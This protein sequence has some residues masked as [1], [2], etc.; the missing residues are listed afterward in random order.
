AVRDTLA[1]AIA[2][3]GS[4]LRDFVDARGKPGYFQQSYF[5]YERAG[6]ACRTCASGIRRLVQGGRST[7]YCPRCQKR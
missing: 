6:E 7:Y 5:V 3:G 4:S 2:A 1:R